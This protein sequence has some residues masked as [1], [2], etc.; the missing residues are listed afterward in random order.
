VRLKP[1]NILYLSSFASLGRGGQESLLHLTA[2]LDR[3][4][5][6]P[7]V[8]LPAEGGLA[9]SLRGHEVEVTILSFP[10]VFHVG[11]HRPL[12]ALYSLLRLVDERAI[13]L[14]HTDGPRNTF[15]AGL[16]ARIKGIPLLWHIRASNRD[17]FDRPLYYLSTRLILVAD[18]LRSRFSWVAE[19]RKFVTIHNG[20]DLS[21]FDATRF[22]HAMR[23]GYGI[24][25]KALLIATIAR[26][27]RLKGQKYLIEACQRM[28]E[29]RVDFH[30]LLVGDVAEPSYLRECRERAAELGIERKITFTGYQDRVSQILNETDVFVL[31]SLFEAFP[32]SLIEAMGAGKPVIATNVG[33][34]PEAVTDGV[35]GFIVPPGDPKALAQKLHLLARDN[36]LRNTLGNAARKRAEE[37]FSIQ[38][39]IGKTQ[40]LYCEL[41]GE[42]AYGIGKT[43]L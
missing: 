23:R 31:P 35:S 7:H 32:R 30:I 14:I 40:E 3:K 5:F 42:D 25:E 27:E 24:S 37:L 26:V 11:I 15:Y 17:R 6:H 22:V 2:N 36:E 34:C 19:N 4:V 16:V 12:R 29:E 1:F 10:A 18:S 28:S 21:V 13:D 8:V 20:I 43:K 33:G 38:Q 9:G 41:L 39:H